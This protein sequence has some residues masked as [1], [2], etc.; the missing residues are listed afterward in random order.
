ML[1]GMPEAPERAEPNPLTR[2]VRWEDRTAWPLFVGALLMFGCA[3]LLWVDQHPSP[4]V[5]AASGLAIGALWIWFAIDYLIRLMLAKGARR[6]FFRSRIFDL[7]SI[8]LPFLRPFL[9]LVVIWRL[10]V[11]R[12]AEAG[13]LR[14]RYGVVTVLFAF[15]YVYVCSYLVW[16]AEKNAPRANILNFEDAVWWGFTTISTVGYGDFVPITPLGR[17]LAVGLMIGGIVVVGFVTAT[18]LS[19]LTDRIRLLVRTD[20]AKRGEAE[21]GTGDRARI[22]QTDGQ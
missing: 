22:A 11:F 1:E 5:Q 21:E 15:I 19:S 14:V 3:T 7:G 16:A 4:L 12:G 8:A 17:T 6:R 18:L 13:R 2:V 9:V 10:P 20:A